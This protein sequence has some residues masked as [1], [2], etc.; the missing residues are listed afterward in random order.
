[1]NEEEQKAKH[2][3]KVEF[4][5]KAGQSNVDYYWTAGAVSAAEN[6]KLALEVENT[7]S[8]S[9]NN[10]GGSG[11]GGGSSG[12]SIQVE[13]PFSTNRMLYLTYL[14]TYGESL[15]EEEEEEEDNSNGN[16]QNDDR[17]GGHAIRQCAVR[18][19]AERR[20]QQQK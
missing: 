13:N 20:Q 9:N 8:N 4:Y 11:S 2:L 14:T 7:N 1:M 15:A 18:I 10:G 12:S 16:N 17:G 5:S 19:K 6:H 3:R